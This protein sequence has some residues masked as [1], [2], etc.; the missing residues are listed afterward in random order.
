MAHRALLLLGLRRGPVREAVRGTPPPSIPL[1]HPPSV[2]HSFRVGYYPSL[3]PSICLPLLSCGLLS[4]CCHALAALLRSACQ[5]TLKSAMDLLLRFCCLPVSH[6]A[7]PRRAAQLCMRTHSQP[8]RA[9]PHNAQPAHSRPD[10]LQPFCGCVDMPRIPTATQ[11]ACRVTTTST[12][13]SAQR[14]PSL[15]PLGSVPCARANS[16]TATKRHA[17][18]ARSAKSV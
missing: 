11:C 15:S 2:F 3:T 13:S 17:S 7:K 14:A 12:R 6:R 4:C 18:P 8:C 1:L 16:A 9:V 10:S 5:I